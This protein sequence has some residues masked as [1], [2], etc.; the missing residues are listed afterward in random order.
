MA[1]SAGTI[2]VYAALQQA[3]IW[4]HLLGRSPG[5]LS[6]VGPR[7]WLVGRTETFRGAPHLQSDVD[8][9]SSALPCVLI[10]LPP[11]N[12]SRNAR[13]TT[14]CGLEKCS[15]PVSIVHST[16][17]GPASSMAASCVARMLRYYAIYSISLI[18]LSCLV[19]LAYLIYLRRPGCVL[20]H[21]LLEADA[22]SCHGCPSAQLPRV[23]V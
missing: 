10:G 1:L 18:S 5:R 11:L 20:K 6:L 3:P 7:E 16:M 13:K 14:H 8:A 22:G 23:C 17:A 9:H 2:L 12:A 4:L 21:S 15:T 19:Y